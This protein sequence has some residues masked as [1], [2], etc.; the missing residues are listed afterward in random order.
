MTH[1]QNTV[2]LKKLAAEIAARAT[3]PRI[4]VALAGAPGSGKSTT[5]ELLQTALQ[6][7]HNQTAQIIP[8]DGFHFDDAIL[9]QLD[10][11]Q[12]K[13][14]PDTFDVDG[15]DMTLSRLATAY[16]TSDV[17]VPIFDR[18]MELSRASARLI[19]RNT[20]IL[21]VEGNYLLLKSAPWRRLHR[22]FVVNVIIACD[23]KT[24][25]K[26]LQKRWTNLGFSQSEATRKVGYNDLSN[27][28]RVVEDSVQAD[29][30]LVNA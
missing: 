2:V 26:R 7:T 17:A 12:K 28:R 27:A 3:A 22:Y 24:L 9:A 8:M 30:T 29:F 23:E 10:R 1:P 25:C 5:A 15:L 4:I 21:L 6:E 16:L 18:A 19:D 20:R 14:A 11:S 13:G